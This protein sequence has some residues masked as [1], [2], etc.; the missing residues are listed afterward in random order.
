LTRQESL[1]GE[2][3]GEMPRRGHFLGLL[4]C[5]FVVVALTAFATPAFAVSSPTVLT[6]PTTA[7]PGQQIQVTVTGLTAPAAGTTQCVGLL[8]PGQNVELG[9]S[10]AFR[11]N[12][13][14][15]AVSTVGEGHT[16]VTLPAN[17]VAGSFRIVVGGCSPNGFVAPLAP[18]ASATI[19][20]VTAAAPRLPSSGGVPIELVVG[21]ALFVIALGVVLRRMAAARQDHP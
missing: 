2:G 1:A 9:L 6:S 8:G 7:T 3:E 15:V 10:P 19:T 5:A 16:S 11:P 21:L 4:G 14:A 20:V 18:V 13:G 12:L 17:L